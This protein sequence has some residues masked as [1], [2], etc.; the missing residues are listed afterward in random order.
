M[1]VSEWI[2]EKLDKKQHARDTFDCGEEVLNVYLKMRAN[3][4]QNKNLNVTYVAVS[5]KAQRPKPVVGYYTLTNSAL[6]MYCVDPAIR[7]HIP[8]TYDIPTVKIGRFAT[9]K[10]IH[11]QGIGSL[12]LRDAC[13]KLVEISAYSGIKGLE[14][15]AKTEAAAQF[16]EHFGFCRMEDSQKVLF[17]PIETILM[18]VRK[19]QAQS[20]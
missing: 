13:R 20:V 4:E 11:R 17:L 9:H 10:E 1:S 2:I 7:R 8:P 12:M 18:S 14:V 16:Y 19:E 3:Q 6:S 15:F 5:K